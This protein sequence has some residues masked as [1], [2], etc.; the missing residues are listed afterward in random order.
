MHS[1]KEKKNRKDIFEKK[2]ERERERTTKEKKGKERKD[3]GEGGGNRKRVCPLLSVLRPERYA[4]VR[5][6]ICCS[7]PFL[8][9][10]LLI[11]HLF[12]VFFFNSIILIT[13]VVTLEPVVCS[14]SRQQTARLGRDSF[15][16]FLAC[17]E[18]RVF[19]VLL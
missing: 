11:L 6:V 12:F 2:K 9:L 1:K 8:L 18:L 14:R 15:P 16:F 3:C 17:S 13:A 19:L 4:C 7:I 10:L 5:R